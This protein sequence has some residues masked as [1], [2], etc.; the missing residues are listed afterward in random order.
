VW[1]AKS[2]LPRGLL[3]IGLQQRHT[4]IR[5]SSLV[6]ERE[7]LSVDLLYLMTL[8]IFVSR[9]YYITTGMLRTATL[10]VGFIAQRTGNLSTSAQ[11]RAFTESK[12][13]LS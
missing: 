12:I 4:E 1:R 13:D 11:T 7:V 6:F 9:L 10:T 2:S 8:A 3:G 5:L